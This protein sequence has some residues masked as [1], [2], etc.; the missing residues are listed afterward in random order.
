M[1]AKLL[2]SSGYEPRSSVLAGERIIMILFVIFLDD[3]DIER[4]EL[5]GKR[6]VESVNRGKATEQYRALVLATIIVH[7]NATH[8]DEREKRNA[9]CTY[10]FASR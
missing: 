1:V 3:D 9:W 4:Q 2:G 8:R 10:F 7:Q 5:N 6:L